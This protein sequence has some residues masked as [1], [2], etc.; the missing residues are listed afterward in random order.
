MKRLAEVQGVQ[1]YRLEGEETSLPFPTYEIREP[2]DLDGVRLPA[3]VAPR[4][5]L[6]ILKDVFLGNGKP[7]LPAEA[8][9]CLEAFLPRI[10]VDPGNWWNR[11]EDHDSTK[12]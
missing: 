6:E 4:I 8:L 5:A 11:S 10:E 9:Q 2:S 7:F 1:I 12:R 3:D